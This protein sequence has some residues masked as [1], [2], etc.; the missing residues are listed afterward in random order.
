MIKS[1]ENLLEKMKTKWNV[2]PEDSTTIARLLS[3][4]EGVTYI[5]ECL[6]D[7]E[8]YEY[9]CDLKKSYYKIYFQRTK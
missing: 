4:L 3:E 6:G 5:L 8:A 7:S 1:Q 2:D 9:L